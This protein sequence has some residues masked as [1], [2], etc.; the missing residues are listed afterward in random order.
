[1]NYNISAECELYCIIVNNGLGS[2]VMKIAKENGVTGGTILIGKGT[3]HNKLLHALGIDDVR[4]EIVLI[5]A[6]KEVGDKALAEIYKQMNMHKPHRGI[7]FSLPLRQ[8]FGSRINCQKDQNE[9]D[10]NMN[11][12]LIITIVEKGKAE[13]VIDAATSAGSRGGTIVNG[14][15]SGIHETK[16]LFNIEIEPEKELVLILAKKNVTDKITS[17]IREELKIDD[18]GKGIIFILDVTQA[19]GL[20]EGD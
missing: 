1:M 4:K 5:A 13:A 19:Y 10:K 7:G 16:K 2:K 20:Y 6:A 9:E 14:R 8:I 12:N 11:Y 15:G 3:I 17:T 18:P